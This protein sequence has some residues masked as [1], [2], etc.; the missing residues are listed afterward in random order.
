MNCVYCNA[1]VSNFL[2]DMTT[3]TPKIICNNCYSLLDTCNMCEH[4]FKC[5]FEEN[6]SV[7]EPKVV[8]QVS[9]Q[10]PMTVKQQVRNPERIK[11][12][13][14]LTCPCYIEEDRVCGKDPS[15]NPIIWCKNYKE[16]PANS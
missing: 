14:A 16:R 5:D 6:T 9:H 15:A 10:G 2:I 3:G 11:Q 13:C 8:I 7:Q 4:A 12:T 1:D